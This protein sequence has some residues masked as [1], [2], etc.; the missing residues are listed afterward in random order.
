VYLELAGCQL[1]SLPEGF[2]ETISNV[3]VLNLNYNFLT[4]LSGLAGLVRLRKLTVVGSRISGTKALVRAVQ[5]L[6][7]LELVDFR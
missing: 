5:K 6:P 1:S 7:L 3:E 2:A 4:D